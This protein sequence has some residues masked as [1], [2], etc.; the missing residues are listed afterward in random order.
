LIE[1]R[2]LVYG[3]VARRRQNDL[4]GARALVQELEAQDEL[5]GYRGLT[6]AI[7]AW[8]A[9]RDGDLELAVGRGNEA[10][11]DWMPEGGGSS[12]VF[13][14]T[15]RFPL[16]GVEL[17]RGRTDAALEHAKAML[18]PSLQP[19]PP[20]LAAALERAVATRSPDDLRTALEHARPYGYS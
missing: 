5:H 12:G 20:E 11:A 17:E 10:L 6:A 2:C 3:A 18:H 7:A 14:W 1:T 15:A 19:L 13:A 9:Y 8:I 4:D 16:L